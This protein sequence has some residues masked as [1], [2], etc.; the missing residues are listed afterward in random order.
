MGYVISSLEDYDTFLYYYTIVI[1]LSC[2]ITVI[3]LSILGY[4]DIGV[5]SVVRWFMIH[6]FCCLYTLVWLSLTN[7]APVLRAENK[8]KYKS[9]HDVRLHRACP[10]LSSP[11]IGYSRSLLID[12]AIGLLIQNAHPRCHEHRNRSRISIVCFHRLQVC[13]LA[14]FVSRSRFPTPDSETGIN[15]VT[16]I[17]LYQ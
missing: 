3:Q 15:L 5:C 16:W 12:H 17:Q 7:I 13:C 10:Q 8:S 4:W 14:L 11:W 9:S 2:C 6:S 1:L